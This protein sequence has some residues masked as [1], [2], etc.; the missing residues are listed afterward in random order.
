[1]G[2]HV[3]VETL[4]LAAGVVFGIALTEASAWS[5]PLGAFVIRTCGTAAILATAAMSIG[6]LRRAAQRDRGMA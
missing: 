6:P 5:Y 4:H 1:M 2:R 3:L